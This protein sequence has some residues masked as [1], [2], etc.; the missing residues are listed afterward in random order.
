MGGLK[1]TCGVWFESLIDNQKFCGL[2]FVRDNV[3]S[4]GFF[5][6]FSFCWSIINALVGVSLA[7]ISFG[8]CYFFSHFSPVSGISTMGVS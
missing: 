3:V 5:F 6:F 4:G 2:I 7:G 8:G 1:I